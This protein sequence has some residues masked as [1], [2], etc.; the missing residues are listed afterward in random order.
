VVTRIQFRVKDLNLVEEAAKDYLL[1][2]KKSIA[3]LDMILSK[4]F[5]FIHF[6][7]TGGSFV[8]KLCSDYAPDSWEIRTIEAHP[9]IHEIPPTHQSRPVMGM[10]R[11]PFDWYVSWYTYLKTRGDNAFFNRASECGRKSFKDT[12]LSIFSMDLGELLGTECAYA[13]SSYGC[14]LNYTFGNNLEKLRIGRFENLRMDLLEMLKDIVALPEELEYHLLKH[15]RID[16]SD[17]RHYREYYDNQLRDL[18]LER[19]EVVLK[20]FGYRF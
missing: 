5:V 16:E 14:Y 15:P 8:R 10:V 11:N 20:D 13:G 9:T 4:H 17:R 19:D 3:R 18:V 2:L 7:K 6:P 1:H 12:M